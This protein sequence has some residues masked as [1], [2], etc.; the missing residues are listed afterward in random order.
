MTILLW[1]IAFFAIII[2]CA[3]FALRLLFST[4]ILAAYLL[5]LT[6]Y[7]DYQIT[8][9]I[10]DAVFIILAA[11]FNIHSLRREVI[12][13]ILFKYARKLVPSLSKTES[14][15]LKAG[16][17]SFEGDLF[18]GRPDF[19]KLL[20]FSKAK[21]TDEE[22]AFLDGPVE[23]LCSMLDDYQI[24]KDGDMPK[25]VWDFIKQKG[26]LSMIIPKSYGGKEF[27]NWAHASVILKVGSRNL[28]AAITVGVPNS[29][30]PG[31]L[32]LRYG[33]KEQK[34]YYLPRLASG[35][36][37]PCFALTGPRAGSD[38]ASI[39]DF[40]VI[41]YEELLGKKTLGIRLNWDKRYITLA[42]V[43]TL[44][45]LAFKLRD[46]DHLISKKENWGI[47]CALIPRHLPG[48]EIGKRH[49]L[50][51][52]VF[53][54][55][56]I[57]GKNVFIP[58]ELVIG[59][60]KM[61]GQGWR[62]L[63]ECLGAG[64][65]IT[66]PSSGSA[67]AMTAALAS[68]CYAR[69]RH[70]FG[71]AIGKFEGVQDALARI[72]T[73]AYLNLAALRFAV[74]S[75]DRGEQP[76][77]ASAIVKYHTTERS[78]QAVND[79]MD[80]HGG[81]GICLGPKNYLISLYRCAPINITVEGATILTRTM[82]ICGPGS[83]R[84]HPYLFN[85]LTAV[86]NNDLYSFDVNFFGH[87]G[88]LL[89]N[90][91]R[92]LVP[93]LLGSRFL[94][95]PKVSL[96]KNRFKQLARYSASFAVTADVVCLV[97]GAQL[98][99]KESLSAKLGDILSYLYLLSACLKRFHDDGQQKAD[100]PII[101]YL[102]DSLFY[103]IEE[104]LHEVCQ[105]LPNRP[106]ACL[107]YKA[108]FPWGRW[109]HKPSDRLTHEVAD[110]L[111]TGSESFD[112]ITTGIFMTPIDNNPFFK[113]KDAYLKVI[114][115][116]ELERRVRKAQKEGKVDG[117]SEGDLVNDAHAK[118]IINDKELQQLIEVVRLRHEI[119]AVDAF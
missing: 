61:I 117:L 118:S 63:M 47:T 95:A 52:I 14:E 71:L 30:G 88:F 12:T 113:L 16:T 54:N 109:Q 72:G 18:C 26:F 103:D 97:M 20:S 102:C 44:I 105:N 50:L 119:T 19:N 93:G 98:K 78:R 22:Q 111:I 1:C 91:A 35:K 90:F 51:D 45:G 27:S 2:T 65:T 4:L 79:A 34:D 43:A 77:V 36:E 33:T 64:R 108:I 15:A 62:M 59:G 106:L 60:Q 107:L 24:S 5:L 7:C 100:L 101:N 31:E 10:L 69:I 99:R 110:L 41:C 55:G 48:I 21:L 96:I 28:P 38:A 67:M 56:P 76:A 114:E 68:G 92:A 39:P 53:Q 84:C 115:A 94:R 75:L 82:I 85:E 3:Y 25:E 32:L 42:P 116:E 29:L 9:L 73:N 83:M 104:R 86:I 70:Q 6:I 23:E 17:V 40:G 57:V 66:L 74:A 37:I 58:L 8:F 89:R 80:I 87:M 112:R 46:P 81:K 13:K 11:I 49:N